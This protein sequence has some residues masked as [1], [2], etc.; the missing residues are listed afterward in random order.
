MT[1]YIRIDAKCDLFEISEEVSEGKC[2]RRL[3]HI[4]KLYRGLR[5]KH[6]EAKTGK[7]KV[8]T[9]I[10]NPEIFAF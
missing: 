5:F 7:L 3:K 10:V 9:S 4:L 8:T 1:K 6:K 2:E